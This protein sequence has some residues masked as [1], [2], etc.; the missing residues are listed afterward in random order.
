MDRVCHA[1]DEAILRTFV[2]R[3]FPYADGP[4]LSMRTCL[5]TNTPDEHF[6]IDVHPAYPQV[7][8]A[9][10]F[11]GH[12]Y[13]FCSVVGEILADLAESGT[14]AH[15]IALFRLARFDTL[16]KQSS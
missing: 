5:F 10:G 2:Q 13:K 1:E 7:L 16:T 15:D 8:I 9:G 12:G 11:S 3:Y 14:T 6:V 4:T